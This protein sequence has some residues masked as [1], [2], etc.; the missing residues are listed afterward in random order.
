MDI[1]K[2]IA[3]SIKGVKK[4]F[5]DKSVLRGINL[6][7][8]KG[9]I[10]ALLGSN[11][12]GKT[13]LI[14]ILTTLLNQDEGSVNVGGFDI[15]KDSYEVKK[16]ISLTGQFATTEETLDA[17]KNIQLI[18]ELNH[19][20]NIR[21]RSDELLKTFGLY[22]VADKR[23]ES[24]SGGMRRRLDIAMSILSEPEIIFLDEPTTGLDPQNRVTMWEMVKSL[25]E[26]G[27]TIFLTTQYLEEAEM[28]ADKVAILNDGL[29]VNKGTVD[30]LK[31]VL[32][33]G[34][35]EFSFRTLDD[36]MSGKK[37]LNNFKVIE[38]TNNLLLTIECDGTMNDMA[39]L[40][41]QINDTGIE[42]AGFKQKLPTLEEV[43]YK[44][45]EE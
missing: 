18:G 29:I 1:G 7:V 26:S 42:I 45:I 28:L 37:A 32:P 27:T 4:A 2:D 41:N 21:D 23:V 12:A 33:Q 36:L 39:I 11:G 40:F 22:D 44:A 31:K 25:A 35:V 6:E 13:T 14:R 3:I 38:D 8:E 19:L 16:L 15:Q 24:F 9:T 34:V 30:E 20:D 10:F 43:F 17:R 5:K